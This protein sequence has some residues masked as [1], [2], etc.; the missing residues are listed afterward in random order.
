MIYARSL[1]LPAWTSI[2]GDLMRRARA[3]ECYQALRARKTDHLAS[4]ERIQAFKKIDW[5]SGGP[6]RDRFR[7]ARSRDQQSSHWHSPFAR[8][9]FEYQ[10]LHNNDDDEMVVRQRPPPTPKIQNKR[11]SSAHPALFDDGLRVG[12]VQT[13]LIQIKETFSFDLDKVTEFF[14]W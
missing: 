5:S 11:R 12:D 2:T 3:S 7:L 1:F 6:A 14:Y 4:G 10:Y 13:P 9:L 8:S